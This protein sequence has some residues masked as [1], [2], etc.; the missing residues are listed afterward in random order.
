MSGKIH[1]LLSQANAQKLSESREQSS[2]AHAE[3]KFASTSEAETAFRDLKEKLLYIKAWNTNARFMRFSHFNQSGIEQKEVKAQISDFLC[4][5]LTA[6]GKNDWVEIVSINDDENEFVLT[7]CPSHNPT[8]SDS[9]ETATSH[10]FTSDS[11]NNF[12][13]ARRDSSVS[14]YVIGLNEKSNID[15]AETTLEAVRN[16][17]LANF[18]YYSGIQQSEWQSFCENFLIYDEK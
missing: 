6:S 11:N 10:F 8:N 14:I 13:L 17:A 16:A 3:R 1:D 9:D 12:C 4:V 18:G 5:H 7:V 2:L 15:E